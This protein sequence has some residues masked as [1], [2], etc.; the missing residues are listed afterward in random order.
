MPVVTSVAMFDLILLTM[1]VFIPYESEPR[2][3][4]KLGIISH[5]QLMKELDCSRQFILSRIE[6]GKLKKWYIANKVYF[7]IEEVMKLLSEEKLSA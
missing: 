2:A 1:N 7:K 3:I 4:P 5:N 6:E